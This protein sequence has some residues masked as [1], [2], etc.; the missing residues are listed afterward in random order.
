LIAAFAGVAGN[1]A[2]GRL[3]TP[4]PAEGG[5]IGIYFLVALIGIGQIGAIVCS[6]GLLAR[7]IHT[8]E[9][10][11]IV[12]AVDREEEAAQNDSESAPLMPP[13]IAPK[14]QTRAHLK[15]SIAGV[16]SLAGGAGILLLTKVGGLM[17]DKVDTGSP[18]YIMSVF[19]GILLVVGI[20]AA[21]LNYSRSGS[22]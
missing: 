3:R 15:G 21:S 11:K 8:K 9:T 13:L 2:F 1:A 20:A 4:D 10:A 14:S 19:N 16:Y 18:F 22:R 12:A 17:F 7:G 6:L 5:G